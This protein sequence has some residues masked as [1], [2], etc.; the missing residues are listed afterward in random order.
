M[1]KKSGKKVTGILSMVFFLLLFFSRAVVASENPVEEKRKDSR[2]IFSLLTGRIRNEVEFRVPGNSAG[3]SLKD[4]G[5]LRGIYM[6]YAARKFVI[7]SLGHFSKLKNSDENGYLFFGSYSF[8]PAKKIHPTAGFAVEYI[9]FYTQ[10]PPE[11]VFPLN[12]LDVDSSILVF[13]PTLGI[14]YK[15]SCLN[16]GI[17]FKATP[18]VGYFREKVNTVINSI[19]N[20]GYGIP[21]FKSSP[22]D[23]LKYTSAGMNFEISL[24]RF[25]KLDSKVY[26]RFRGDEETL[27]T[28]RNRFDVY[29]SRNFGLTMKIDY[30]QDKYETNSFIFFGVTAVI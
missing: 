21:G 25:L 30:F 3:Q 1:S 2:F 16:N 6:I 17:S 26:F 5:G 14:S 10:M 8:A 11:D 15:N 18:F 12:S 27:Y 9:H 24:Y 13:H 20:A 29:F 23:D 22:S 19:G 7:G 4:D 28:L